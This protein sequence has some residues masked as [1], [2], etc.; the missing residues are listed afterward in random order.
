MNLDFNPE[1][2]SEFKMF[3]H[4]KNLKSEDNN[5]GFNIL[6]HTP[7][8]MLQYPNRILNT[9]I[10]KILKYHYQYGFSNNTG[11]VSVFYK[12]T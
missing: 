7:Q 9:S 3:F 4:P 12:D 11:P 10:G 5:P 8:S 1:F 6:L 2:S